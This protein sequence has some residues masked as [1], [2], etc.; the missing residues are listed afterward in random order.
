MARS[1]TLGGGAPGDTATYLSFHHKEE[2]TCRKL[3]LSSPLA[4]YPLRMGNLE[5]FLFSVAGTMTVGLLVAVRII[6]LNNLRQ[7]VQ[8][9]VEAMSLFAVFQ[10]EC[11][12]FRLRVHMMDEH[13]SEYSAVFHEAGWST[14]ITT[15][16]NMDS[17]QDTLN[18]LTKQRDF[19]EITR[20]IK[21]FN[22]EPVV[23]GE[24]SSRDAKVALLALG[25]WRLK[26]RAIFLNLIENLHEEALRTK[27][28]GVTRA[29]KRQPTLTAIK[30]LRESLGIPL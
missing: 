13:I 22:G 11:N 19:P 25:D 5:I 29:R 28:L 17:L 1:P 14:M 8:E 2:Q 18:K 20:V 16:H 12:D 4:D 24:V 15:L 3:K 6:R 30:A 10:R 9:E 23:D 26:T 27:E 7:K 21:S